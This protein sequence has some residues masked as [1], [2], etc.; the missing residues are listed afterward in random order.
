MS[1]DPPTVSRSA[2]PGAAPTPHSE[3][4]FALCLATYAE[5]LASGNVDPSTAS[6]PSDPDLRARLQHA[7]NVVKLLDE[8]RRIKVDAEPRTLSHHPGRFSYD[9]ATGTGQLGRFEL[10]RELGRGGGGIVF[11]A[12]DPQLKRNVALK[13][14]VLEHLVNQEA[15]RRFLREAEAAAGLDHPNIVPVY[16]AG[17]SGAVAWIA[18]AY[19]DGPTLSRWLRE[20]SQPVS[21]HDAAEFVALLADAVEYTH[22][23]GIVHRDLKPGNILLVRGGAVAG[24]PLAAKHEVTASPQAAT[25]H[26]APLSTYQ[27]KI[28]D[29][30]LAKLMEQP[31]AATR[32]GAVIG[33]V[34]YMAPEQAAG[35]TRDVGPAADIY[36]LGAILYEL[37]VGRPP[38][39]GATELDT[40]R[41]VSEE[42]AVSVRRLRGDVPRDL[43]VICAKCLHKTPAGRYASAQALA[44]DLRRFLRGESIQARPGTSLGRIVKWARRRPTLAAL[45]GVSVLALLALTT[46]AILYS[47]E[48]NQHNTDLEA[49]LGREKDALAEVNKQLKLVEQKEKL[50]HRHYCV[51]Q[52]LNMVKEWEGDKT[53]RLLERLHGLKPRPGEVDSR[54]LEWY[55]LW[56]RY[57]SKSLRLGWHDGSVHGLAFS[58]DGKILASASSD[59]TIRF[60]EAATGE[61]LGTLTGHLEAVWC[62]AFA[63]DGKTLASGC[64]DST[65]KIWDVASRQEL[66]TLRGHTGD[67]EAVLFTP[68]SQTLISSGDDTTIRIWEVKS[69]KVRTIVTGHTDGVERL[70]SSRDGF[71]LAS[72]SGDGTIKLWD[73]KSILAGGPGQELATLDGQFGHVQ[74]LSFSPDGKTL[75]ASGETI[76]LWEVASRK[77]LRTL[78]GHSPSI[79]GLEFSPDGKTLASSSGKDQTVCLWDTSTGA[80]LAT[81]QANIGPTHSVAFSPDGRWLAWSG[82]NHLLVIKDMTA[83]A[84]KSA[85]LGHLFRAWCV[86]FAPDSQTLASGGED[87]LVKLWDV[88]NGKLQTTLGLHG[89]AVHAVAHSP[90]GKKLAA[91]T[92]AGTVDVWDVAAKTRTVLHGHK[93]RVQS[94]AY[95]PDGKLLASGSWDATVKLWDAA[96]GELQ[97]TLEGNS[98]GIWT[99]R[100]SPDGSLLASGSED[101]T[102]RIWDVGSGQLLHTLTLKA[103]Q[104]VLCVAFTPDGKRLI[105]STN[106][107]TVTLW[108]P[109][110]GEENETLTGHTLGV[111]ALSIA[112]DGLTLVTGSTDKTIKFWDLLTREELLTIDA[113]DQVMGL[114]FAPDGKK[115]A[116]A[117]YNGNVQLWR[118]VEE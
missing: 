20:Q 68:D 13:V 117:Y 18:S 107:G 53:A 93:N 26:H 4:E 87:F 94:V 66:D 34:A 54:G 96:T 79:W 65:I 44:D 57:Q 23:R 39:Q 47:I 28:T 36:A 92:V 114:A 63:P 105:S 113:P 70:V 112:P 85:A 15:R 111:R 17:E 21:A 31:G 8:H 1:S 88:T 35:R 77:P 24:L 97:R 10:I 41:Q 83:K 75:A 42:D 49:T 100:F 109:F 9:L 72:G 116:A 108:D 115:L 84:S 106:I 91:A 110:S 50:L 33:T 27:P 38:F 25:T 37:L 99:V 46:G 45:I 90:D 82:A 19:C 6:L 61:P 32:T 118:A 80:K 30:G 2:E 103:K 71:T 78:E 104:K 29:F 69:G 67:V 48:L 58:P 7:Q 64:H 62:V 11:L 60:W 59:R 76:R 86:A 22:R 98:A 56:Q 43:E 89:G 81:Y 5:A 95:S 51:K 101:Q 74:G 102:I 55:V 3:E 14:P 12:H 52:F 16:E 40:L 73:L